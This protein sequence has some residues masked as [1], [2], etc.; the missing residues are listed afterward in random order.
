V[1]IR[2]VPTAYGSAASQALRDA[3]ARAKRAD[4][5]APVTVV[6]PTN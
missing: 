6:V 5:L 3:V 1:P 2:V 4:V